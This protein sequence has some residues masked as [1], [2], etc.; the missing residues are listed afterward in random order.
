MLSFVMLNVVMP[1]IIALVWLGLFF[2]VSMSIQMRKIFVITFSFVKYSNL[3]FKSSSFQGIQKYYFEN[4]RNILKTLANKNSDEEKK[5]FYFL[6]SVLAHFRLLP[7]YSERSIPCDDM[8]LNSGC[9]LDW[10]KTTPG[11]NF[12]NS[13]QP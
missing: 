10:C 9:S 6:F 2:V 4:L 7:R 8:E 3:I 1:I 5:S 13:L 11:I 12:Y